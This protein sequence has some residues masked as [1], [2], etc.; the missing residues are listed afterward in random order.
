MRN[1]YLGLTILILA[2]GCSNKKQ[3]DKIIRNGVI[4]D[5]RGGVPYKADVA[6]N[7]DTIAEIG[8]LP[9]NSA[10]EEIDAHDM[11]VAPG[12]INMLSWANE[13]LIQDG[14][15]QSDI[16]QGVT[17]DV[18][19]EGSSMGPLNP[20]MK[21]EMSKG[22]G[23]IHYKVAW[24]TLGEYLS[25]MEKKGISCN[26]AS[27]IGAGTVRTNVIGEDNRPPSPAE[28]EKMQL[29]VKQAMQEGAMGVGSSLIYPPDFFAKTDELIALCKVASAYG[30]SYISHMR[31]EGNKLNEAVAELIMIAKQAHIH[32]EIYHLKAAGK[33][34]WHKMDSVIRQVETARK[35]GLDITA[36]M[37]TY[38]AG[39]T[40]LTASFPPSL[41]DGGFGKL[42]Q[43]LHDPVIRAQMAK[44]MNTNATTWE[45]LYYGAGSP[46][47]VL[48][49]AF[50]QD[51]LKKYTGKTLAEVAKI[52]RKSPE[53]TAMDLIVQD[54]T[55]IGVAY[56]LM[57]EDNV[58]KQV[59]LPWVSFGSDEGSFSNSGIFLKSNPHPRA[60]GNFIR[61]LGQYT[62]DDK[63]IT[64]PDAIRKLA[65]LPA[66]NLK[67]KKRGALLKGYYADVVI[68]DPQK[69]QDHATYAKPHQY[70]TGI[71][72]VFVN[73]VQVLKDGEHTGALPGRFIKGPGYGKK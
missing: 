1:Y 17:L 10:K 46:D 55:R 44:A 52:R 30:G 29:L 68:F 24:N 57:S 56:F 58:K 31:S 37:Y 11:A 65:Y 34:N 45:N 32:A 26:I 49:L 38:L 43:R 63:V 70:A 35:H 3:Y 16:R 27:F 66:T 7:A 72:G 18:M 36:D 21:A 6:I 20:K 62:R 59:A 51:S 8:N 25:Y 5:G 15:S 69:V 60:Y 19:G 23:D 9:A 28:L 48:L 61:V 22:Q 39:A 14:R 40:G 47:K 71:A 54:S 42:W 41:Q 33:D 13:S 67:L 50:K 64:L 4:Y 12:F 2:A 73:G 53:E